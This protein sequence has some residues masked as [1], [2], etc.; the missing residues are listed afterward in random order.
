M[1]RLQLLSAIVAVM[2]LLALSVATALAADVA[3]RPA[4]STRVIGAEASVAPATSDSHTPVVTTVGWRRYAYRPYG[5]YGYRPYVAPYVVARPYYYGGYGGYYGYPYTS[6]YGVGPRVYP[7]PRVYGY[8][9]G[10]VW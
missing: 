8:R 1:K 5:Y 6:Y 10:Y 4:I 2:G 3:V 9:P 7:A